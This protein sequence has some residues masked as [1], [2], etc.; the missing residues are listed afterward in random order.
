M[1]QLRTSLAELGDKM[2]KV[3]TT[4]SVSAH[5]IGIYYGEAITLLPM[6]G[7]HCIHVS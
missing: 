1:E 4:S 5:R 7:M 2:E 3:E 6:S